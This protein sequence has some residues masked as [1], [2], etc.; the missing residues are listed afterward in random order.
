MVLLLD[1]PFS[2]LDAHL[3]AN[4]FDHIRKLRDEEGMTI[5]I[6]SHDG[7]DVLGL[8]DFI[9]FMNNGK[10]GARK[11]PFNA[12]YNLK[13][14]EIQNCLEL[15]IKLSLKKRKLDSGQTNLKMVTI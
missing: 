8:S 7:Q 5:I 1:E 10:I 14:L 15:L 11:T 4:L 13:H 9:Y 6:V 12:Y 3:R 2:N